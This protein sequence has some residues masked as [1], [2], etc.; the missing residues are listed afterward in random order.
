MPPTAKRVSFGAKSANAPLGSD[1][2]S[3][4]VEQICLG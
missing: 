3:T 2:W 4:Q 1:T